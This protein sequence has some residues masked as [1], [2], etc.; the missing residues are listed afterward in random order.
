MSTSDSPDHPE[1]PSME[2][3]ACLLLAMAL[4]ILPAPS[5][6]PE[7]G[8][9][10][11]PAAKLLLRGRIEDRQ[12]I[13][14]FKENSDEH[15]AYC[16]ALIT[17]HAAAREA[18]AQ[19]ARLDVTYAHLFEQPEEYRGVLVHV[20]GRMRRLRRFES[21]AFVRE[22]YDIP[23]IY[24]GWTFDSERY[25]TNPTCLIF[26]ELPQGIGIGE[27]IDQHVSFDGYFFKRYR[28]QAGDGW[29][30]APLIIGKSPE[31]QPMTHTGL[32]RSFVWIIAGLMGSGTALVAVLAWW[33]RRG[34]RRVYAVLSATRRLNAAMSGIDEAAT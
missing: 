9:L 22:S 23:F 32:P 1:T 31:L 17:S 20:T 10:P 14:S 21:P 29:R 33:Y 3:T 2:P 18:L 27:E 11:E 16:L 34:D 13:R 24:E 25:G 28:Y 4:G 12:P 30:D 26:T 5:A 7:T 19:K 8:P 15:N 6:H